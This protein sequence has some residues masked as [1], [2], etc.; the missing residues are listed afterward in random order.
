M[1][2]VL[3]MDQLSGTEQASAWAAAAAANQKAV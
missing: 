3:D 1:E 2:Q